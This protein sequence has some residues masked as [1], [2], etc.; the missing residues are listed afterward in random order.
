LTFELLYFCPLL[1]AAQHLLKAIPLKPYHHLIACRND[2]NASR[3]RNCHHLVQSSPVF[4]HIVLGKFVAF[5]R[6]K[7]FRHRAIGSSRCR[8]NFD[9]I[10]CHNCPSSLVYRFTASSLFVHRSPF[11]CQPMF[12]LNIP[13]HRLHP[14]PIPL[15]S[16]GEGI[17]GCQWVFASYLIN[18]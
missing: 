11:S 12:F 6:K 14:H 2:R 10:F 18:P 5:L 13:F 15:P 8:I 4:G 7:L 9:F 17:E 16:K 3:T 1:D